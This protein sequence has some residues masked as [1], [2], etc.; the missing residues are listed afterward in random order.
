MYD[1]VIIGGGIIGVTVARELSKYKLK[2]ILLEKSTELADVGSASKANSGI[3]HAGHDCEIGTLKAKLNVEGNRLYR[4][5]VK[6]LSIPYRQNGSFVLSFSE[7]QNNLLQNLVKKAEAN[8]VPDVRILDKEEVLGMEKN[9]NKN[10]QKALY[11]P[12][13]GIISPYE[14]VYAFAENAYINGVEFQ[15]ETEITGIEK[16]ENAASLRSVCLKGNPLYKIKTTKGEIFTKTVVN[17]AGVYSDVMNNFVSEKKYAI[18]ARKGEYVLYDK[19]TKGF[20]NSTIFLPPGKYGKGVLV[21]PTV[22]HNLLVGP[23]AEYIDDKDSVKTH[24]ETLKMVMETGTISMQILPNPQIITSFTGLRS[25]IVDFYDFIIEEA[26]GAKGFVNALGINSPGLTAAPAI[27]ERIVCIIT[28]LLQPKLNTEFI[29][30]RE[31]MNLF[32]EQTR[33]NQINMIAKD[34][35]YGK[36]VC[37]CE[38]VTEADIINSIRRPLGATTVDGVKRR[39]RAGMGRCQGGFCITK[40]MEILSK[41]LEIDIDEITKFGGNSYIL[42]RC[43]K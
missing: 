13:G 17:A 31:D 16:A 8:G 14:A 26:E 22:H 32:A 39:T 6:E 24:A 2:V 34:K 7:E 23:S 38:T 30:I 37:R 25:S 35:K 20:V 27:A 5:L 4:T 10:V 3:I 40:V 43:G 19:S 36:I 9:V 33:E 11:A 1:V 29:K 41:E 21:T 15:F 42:E 28:D 18:K 12:S